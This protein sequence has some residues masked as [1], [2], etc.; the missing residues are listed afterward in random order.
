MQDAVDN[1]QMDRTARFEF[2]RRMRKLQDI[3][4]ALGPLPVST[5]KDHPFVREID[6]RL[7]QIYSQAAD[8]LD[9]ARKYDEEA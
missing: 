2:R 6:R 3:E 9:W 4:R 1:P 7:H 5:K 8:A